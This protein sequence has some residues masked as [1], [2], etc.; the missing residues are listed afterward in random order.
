M[1]KDKEQIDEGITEIEQTRKDLN[2]AGE[3]YFDLIKMQSMA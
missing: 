1:E 3:V 2:K